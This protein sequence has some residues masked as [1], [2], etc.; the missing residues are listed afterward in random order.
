MTFNFEQRFD[1]ADKD[2]RSIKGLKGGDIRKIL[3]AWQSSLCDLIAG[4]Q[5]SKLAQHGF[6]VL[7]NGSWGSGKTTAVRALLKG[8]NKQ[9]GKKRDLR[10]VEY[11]F[12]PFGNVNESIADFINEL[13]G[14]L[15]QANW[16]DMRKEVKCLIISATPADDTKYTLGFNTGL[17]TVG[18]ERGRQK[19]TF[20]DSER[21]LYER[22][23]TLAK[24]RR[25]VVVTIDDI[26]RLQPDETVAILRLIEKLRKLP[27]LLIVVPVH[28][29]IVSNAVQEHL[30][31]PRRIDAQTFLR[32]AT[33]AE[34]SINNKLATLKKVFLEG[35]DD[36]DKDNDL[37]KLLENDPAA[38]QSKALQYEGAKT[39][40][41]LC[42]YTLLHISILEEAITDIVENSGDGEGNAVARVFNPGSSEYLA[43][44]KH[45]LTESRQK[46]GDLYPVSNSAKKNANDPEDAAIIL[47]A[48]ASVEYQPLVESSSGDPL[49]H[50]K[51]LARKVDYNDKWTYTDTGLIDSLKS[52]NVEDNGRYDKTA[53]YILLELFMTRLTTT[54]HEPFITENLHGYYKLRDVKELSQKIRSRILVI[55]DEDKT[56]EHYNI[57]KLI[58]KT[59]RESFE[60][61]RK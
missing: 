24:K 32:K 5:Q 10:F 18:I 33:D 9:C 6:V 26:D 38:M 31:L 27:N 25:T 2:N 44:I 46:R 42:W 29:T 8:V 47:P 23:N 37:L 3:T 4:E 20:I 35:W 36:I 59:V 7:M 43:D 15:W 54:T 22:F 1:H 56:G 53:R 60:E 21:K 45:L 11:S 51:L 12:L 40:S 16:L 52:T 19:R 17:F 50:L 14:Q 13:A 49:Q 39:I 55:H 41:A 28:K 61:F 48:G 58:F 57:V 34:F 30:K